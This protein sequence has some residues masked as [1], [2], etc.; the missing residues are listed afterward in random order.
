MVSQD[1]QGNCVLIC[2]TLSSIS[3]YSLPL[4]GIVM[5]RM[6]QIA[7]VAILGLALVLATATVYATTQS[8]QAQACGPGSTSSAP[9][10]SLGGGS[11][12]GAQPGGPV[13]CNIG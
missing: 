1:T 10:E 4:A 5:F 3:L 11:F 7:M 2:A 9:C 6:K 8:A 13:E 12:S